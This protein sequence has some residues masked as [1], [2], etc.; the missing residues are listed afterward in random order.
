V[1]GCYL[2]G[3]FH[4]DSFR[5]AWLKK[6]GWRGEVI[7]QSARYEESLEKLADAVENALN[8][9]LLEKIIWDN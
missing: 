7:S 3:L 6:L 4:N 9:D 8:M 1:W 2:H 5:Q